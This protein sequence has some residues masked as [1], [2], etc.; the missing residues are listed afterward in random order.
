MKEVIRVERNRV[1]N[2]RRFFI[3]SVLILVFSI[4]SSISSM[5]NYNIYDSSGKITI[6]YKDNLRES[7]LNKHNTVLGDKT[8]RDVVDR[9]D[10]SIYLYNS[11]LIRFLVINYNEK[12]F[13]E[14]TYADISNFYDIRMLNIKYNIENSLTKFTSIQKIFLLEKGEKIQIPLQI[15]YAEGWKNLNNDMIDFIPIILGVIS[16]IILPIYAEDP[17]TK[18]KQLYITSKQG[19]KTLIKARMIAGLE[20]GFIIYFVSI[21]IFSI[22]KLLIFGVKGHNLHIQNSINYFLSTYNITYLQQYLLNVTMGFIAMLLISS[23]TFLFTVLVDQILS[24][25]VL[26]AFFWIL[27]IIIPAHFTIT[28]YFSNFLPYNMTNFNKYYIGNEVYTI[29]GKTIP[30]IIWVM[31]VSFIIF[32]IV[33]IT[34]IIISNMKLSRDIK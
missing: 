27:S 32:I 4:F 17:K 26:L 10:K 5:K 2:L 25:A 29:L 14:I 7:K 24:G 18:M 22:S 23:L 15:G 28:H 19:K 30:S 9:K 3:L 11:N 20:I 16:V 12:K 13:E 31:I 8:L 34:T 21:L 33:T 1:L 6:S